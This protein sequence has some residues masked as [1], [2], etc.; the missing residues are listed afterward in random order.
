[1]GLQAYQRIKSRKSKLASRILDDV[2]AF[3]NKNQFGNQ[4]LKIRDYVCW[5]LKPDG[6]AYYQS[7]TPQSNKVNRGHKD[8]VVSLLVAVVIFNENTQ[9]ICHTFQ[10][11]EGFLQSELITQTAEKFLGYAKKS[12]L[13]PILMRRPP[14]EVSTCSFSL[15]YDIFLRSY[16]ASL[17]KRFNSWNEPLLPPTYKEPS[18][19]LPNSA[20]KIIGSQFKTSTTTLTV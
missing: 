18:F 15:R 4:P 5:A 14:R 20:M 10:A 3:F 1:L 8:Y 9:G 7:P 2:K 6:P 11:P 19:N 16:A 13:T 17:R 12:V